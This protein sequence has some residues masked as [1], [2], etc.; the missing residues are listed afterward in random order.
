MQV[1]KW[2]VN[3]ML[4]IVFLCCAVTGIFKLTVFIRTLG[5]TDIVL[6]SAYLSNLHDVSGITLCFLVGVH[7]FLNRAWIL[8]M[9]QKV[10]T[11]TTN[12]NEG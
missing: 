12:V 10:V 9:T 1:V 4:G 8:S 11:G 7:L 2:F 3:L 6:P 5:L